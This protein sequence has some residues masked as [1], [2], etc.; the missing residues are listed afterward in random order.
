MENALI[1]F[2]VNQYPIKEYL[3]PLIKKM[4]ITCIVI[5]L[6]PHYFKKMKFHKLKIAYLLSSIQNY[7]KELKEFVKIKITQINYNDNFSAKNNQFYYILNPIDLPVIKHTTSQIKTTNFKIITD[8]PHFLIPDLEL[9]NINYFRHSAFYEFSKRFIKSKYGID[10]TSITNQDKYNRKRIPKNELIKIKD[11][12]FK[13]DNTLIKKQVINFVNKHFKNNFG[14][15]E[16]LEY[17]PI[18]R[19]DALSH[20]DTFLKTNIH[21]FGD[22]QDFISKEHFKL[23]HSMLS[24]AIN[25]GILTPLDIIKKLN[26]LK[27]N[28]SLN[29]YEGFL[30]QIIGWREY[31]HFIYYKNCKL[32]S[33]SNSWN[34]KKS[35]PKNWI[36]LFSKEEILK[37]EIEKIRNWG[38]SHHI[39]RLMVFLNYFILN[40]YS[41]NSIYVWFMENIALDAYTWVMIPNIYSMGYFNK[42]Y[43]SKPYISSSNYLKNMSNYKISDNWTKLYH[44]KK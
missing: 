21:K 31:M 42:N 17:L 18:S 34:N 8:T 5:Y 43:T 1:I 4:K 12:T 19:K 44:S 38:W 36:K 28:I 23:Y 9:N 41:P 2:P 20:L 29:S 22:Y 39:I 37:Y 11:M 14:N 25:I 26:K 7:I 16:N 40:G 27:N 15:C 24:P 30:R 35:I 10:F 6:H 13:T 3:I 33:S 32:V